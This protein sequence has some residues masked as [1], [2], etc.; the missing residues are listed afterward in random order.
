MC[1]TN[2]TVYVLRLSCN[3]FPTINVTFAAISQRSDAAVLNH[4]IYH[5]LESVVA[6]VVDLNMLECFTRVHTPDVNS[7]I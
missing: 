2:T 4:K 6:L 7:K 5:R 3:L 1:R